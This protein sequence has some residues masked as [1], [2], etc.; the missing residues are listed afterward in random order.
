MKKLA[1]ITILSLLIFTS[2]STSSVT[3]AATQIASKDSEIASLQEEVNNLNGQITYLTNLI[4]FFEHENYAIYNIEEPVYLEP[5]I[6]SAI[7]ENQPI[8]VFVISTLEDGDHEEWLYVENAHPY[9]STKQFG[10]IKASMAELKPVNIEY[11]TYKGI[12]IGGYCIG[13]SAS[14][15]R[16]LYNQDISFDKG[17]LS[18]GIRYG[19]TIF[20]IDQINWRINAIYDTDSNVLLDD[21]FRVGDHARAAIDYYSNKYAIFY[22]PKTMDKKPDNYFDLGDNGLILVILYDTEELTDSSVIVEIKIF[23]RYDIN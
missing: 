9:D 12:N 11:T 19:E 18:W 10:Y 7:V 14:V 15:L 21:L 1:I 3:D 23:S 5:S 8:R 22:S 20:S 2:C 4:D 6:S 17:E 13:D 16:R